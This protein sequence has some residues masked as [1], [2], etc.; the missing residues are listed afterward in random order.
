[1]EDGAL[2]LSLRDEEQEGDVAIAIAIDRLDVEVERGSTVVMSRLVAE[3][4]DI[5]VIVVMSVQIPRVVG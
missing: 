2:K 1:M 3:L 4:N 5:V